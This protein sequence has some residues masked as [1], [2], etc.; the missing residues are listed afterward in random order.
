MDR[1][2]LVRRYTEMRKQAFEA[3]AAP[4]LAALHATRSNPR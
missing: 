4:L 3:L 2:E 1:A